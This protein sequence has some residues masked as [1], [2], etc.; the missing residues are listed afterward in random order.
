MAGRKR[1]KEHEWMPSRVYQGRSAYEW[2][3]S[4]G[5]VIRLCGLEAG[6]EEV[7]NAYKQ[8]LLEFEKNLYIEALIEKFF[9]STDFE[10][11]APATQVDYRKYSKKII[12]VFGRMAPDSVEPQHI[13]R[14]MDIR[15]RHSKVQANREKAF[16]SR[17]FRW[18]YE[19]GYAKRNPCQGV[20]QFKEVARD[21]YVTDAEYEAVYQHACPVVR[22]AMEI[23]YLCA[24]RQGD[25]LALK[26]SQLLEEG[27]FIQ[28]G[29]T[30]KKQIKAWTPALR[31]AVSECDEAF[32]NN[33]IFVIHQS[34]GKQY[35]RDVFSHRWSKVRQIA[36]AATG[37]PLDFTF[38]DLKAKGISDYEGSVQD[39]QIFS[40]HKT[41]RQVSTYNRKV[42]VVQTLQKD[43]GRHKKK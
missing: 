12:P 34:T 10:D 6:H 25:V 14:Y 15:G 2:R 13:R 4:S 37:L 9:M 17:M 38:H 16:F 3:P 19:R 22:A 28:Q 43:I 11:L 23:S 36:R 30:G 29:K 33:S 35:S 7:W 18:A 31:K 39:K 26:K 1:S 41:E 27:I 40:G 21:R 24:A 5:G 42:E 20:R 32:G 8:K